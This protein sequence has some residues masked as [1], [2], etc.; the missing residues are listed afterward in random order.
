M[1]DYDKK[2]TSPFTKAFMDEAIRLSHKAM[3]EQQGGPFGAVIVKDDEI[4]ARGFN[5]VVACCDP[6]AHAEIVAIR[7]AAKKLNNF[8]LSGC[9]IYTSAEPCPMCLAAIYWARL[10]AIYFSNT[11]EDTASIGFDDVHLYREICLAP[12]ERKMPMVRILDDEAIEVFRNW[13]KKPDKVHY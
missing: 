2:N 12:S 6:T 10:D 9:V 1:C 11:C 5:Q 8:D 4:I 7:A 13:Q 3:V